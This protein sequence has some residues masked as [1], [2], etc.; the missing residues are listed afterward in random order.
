M[1]RNFF[2]MNSDEDMIDEGRLDAQFNNKV[3]HETTIE[4]GVAARE[5][6]RNQRVAAHDDQYRYEKS[7]CL[8]SL[9]KYF[10]R[11]ESTT[12]K[13]DDDTVEQQRQTLRQ[14]GPR[15]TQ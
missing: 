4:D 12:R 5:H 10:Q 11:K 6:R 14:Q 9:E 8:N 7:V 2:Q 3:L 1:E 15:L 13:K